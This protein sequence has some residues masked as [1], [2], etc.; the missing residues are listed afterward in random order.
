[1]IENRA[2]CIQKVFSKITNPVIAQPIFLSSPRIVIG[3]FDCQKNSRVGLMQ[4]WL[5]QL[6]NFVQIAPHL[7]R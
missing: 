1:M 3:I 5:R 4:A 7:S 6:Q 2:M